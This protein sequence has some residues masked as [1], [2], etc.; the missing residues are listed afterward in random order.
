MM[1][2][3]TATMTMLANCHLA[4]F[5]IKT[6]KFSNRWRI[7]HKIKINNNI[8][9]PCTLYGPDNVPIGTLKNS[10]ALDYVRAQIACN[11]LSGYY[12][13][14][15]VF[16]SRYDIDSAGNVR[17]SH[18]DPRNPMYFAIVTAKTLMMPEQFGL[19]YVEEYIESNREPKWSK[20]KI[21]LYIVE[22]LLP[23][24]GDTSLE[25]HYVYNYAQLREYMKSVTYDE[26]IIYKVDLCHVAYK[27][28]IKDHEI[29]C[30]AKLCNLPMTAYKIG[31]DHKKLDRVTELPWSIKNGCGCT[32]STNFING[33]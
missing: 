17:D 32:C 25:E 24:D 2:A 21:S 3:V 22:G 29:E 11:H 7:M 5:N 14:N 9:Q 20:H 33:N 8:E 4:Y 15:S 23:E 1:T 6:C 27:L 19:D 31:S 13:I 30:N 18:G 26:D 16:G 28:S 12:I 10:E